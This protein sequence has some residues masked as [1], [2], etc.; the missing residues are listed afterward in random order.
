MGRLWTQLWKSSLKRI[1]H[2]NFMLFFNICSN[3]KSVNKGSFQKTAHLKSKS[4]DHQ[5]SHKIGNLHSCLRSD[6][7]SANI[8]VL[9]YF[10]LAYAFCFLTS[11]LDWHSHSDLLW[12]QITFSR[13][14]NLSGMVFDLVLKNRKFKY[15]FSVKNLNFY[16]FSSNERYKSRLWPWAR[17]T[18]ELDFH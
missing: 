13:S 10:G 2:S 16:L 15:M 18:L 1:I 14:R 8:S 17:L 12:N 3:K 4:Q 7:W 6:N 11:S 9:E 5:V